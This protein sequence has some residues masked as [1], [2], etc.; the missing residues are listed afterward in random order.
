MSFIVLNSFPGKGIFFFSIHSEHFPLYFSFKNR[1]YLTVFFQLAIC[2]GDS[3]ISLHGLKVYSFL[4]VNSILS[5][6]CTVCLSVHL[7][8]DILVASSLG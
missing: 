3:S 4:F 6:E 2:I 7:L 1:S 8:K 5:Y